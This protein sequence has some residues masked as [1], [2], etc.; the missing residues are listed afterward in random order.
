[1]KKIDLNCDMGEGF[2]VYRL[3][4]DEKIIHHITSANIACAWHAGDPLIMNRTVKMAV[5]NSVAV[6]AHPGYPDRMGFG[7]R[8][9]DCT[10]QEIRLY[11][12]Y[13]IGALQAFCIA[14]NTRLQHVK[15]HGA[16]YLMAVEN[17]DIARAVAE[18]IIGVNSEL[19]YVALAGK[20]G[21]LMAQVGRE[22]GLKIAYEAFPDRA[23]TPEGTLQSR[24]EPGAV[25][26][27]PNEVTERALRMVLEERVIA[28]DGSSIP[29]KANTLC[30]H[31]DTP[32]AVE[33]T[34]SI[35]EALEAEGVTLSSMGTVLDI[36]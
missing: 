8:N 31:G 13:Q 17:A 36:T 10:L 26:E 7:R 24:Q 21:E 20:K 15:P 1:M 29:L 28:I 4:M 22:I 23:Y 33:L 12:T 19:Y 3:G 14:N 35:R 27:E 2:G 6:G 5:E 32:T 18:A 30:V 25:I 16:L 9:M 11:V 34:K